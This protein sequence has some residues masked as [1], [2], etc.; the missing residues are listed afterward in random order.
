MLLRLTAWAL[1]WLVFTAFVVVT[2]LTPTSSLFGGRAVVVLC[3][4]SGGEPVEYESQTPLPVSD[5]EA[6]K[7]TVDANDKVTL[8]I[9][10]VNEV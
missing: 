2:I 6:L 3:I 4:I 1:N 7:G 9:V 8:S 10:S 5:T